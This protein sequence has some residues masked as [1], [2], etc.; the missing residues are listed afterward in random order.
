MSV[1][2]SINWEAQYEGEHAAGVDGILI[3]QGDGKDNRLADAIASATKGRL[4]A[5]MEQTDLR[6]T[7][8]II[9]RKPST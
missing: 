4:T 6:S 7:R 2:K 5:N 9:G 1:F 8:L 3:A